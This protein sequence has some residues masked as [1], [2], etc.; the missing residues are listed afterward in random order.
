M[1]GGAV[2]VANEARFESEKQLHGAIA[3]HPEVLPSEDV[4]VGPLVAVA[5]ELD[6]GAGPI[7]LLAVD[8]SGRL[9]IVE[10]RVAGPAAYSGGHGATRRPAPSQLPRPGMSAKGGILLGPVS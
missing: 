3:E 10:S 6:V 9:V 7:D 5:N 2:S 8:G 4:G 1:D